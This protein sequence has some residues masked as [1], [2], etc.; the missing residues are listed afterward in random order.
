[1]EPYIK[2]LFKKGFLVFLVAITFASCIRPQHTV[3]I[4]D[5]VLMPNGK[6]VLGRDKGLTAFIFENN[7][8]KI[9]F[10]QFIAN[11]Y[12]VGTYVDVSYDVDLDGHRFK[13]FVYEN[14]ELE[15]Y[16]DMSQFMVTKAETEI[17][18][19]G[20]TARFLGMSVINDYN[21]D[22]LDDNSLYKNITIAYLKNL[23]DEYNK[24]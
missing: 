5:Y 4:Q 11:K 18:I 17:N 15:K 20:S 21:E 23:T 13:V 12:N 6:E 19:V 22:C 10:V 14:A 1:M 8:R 3:E 9:P 16:F 24:L 2:T 7:P